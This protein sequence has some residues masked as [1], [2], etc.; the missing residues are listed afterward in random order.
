MKKIRLII[1]TLCICCLSAQA[2]VRIVN[3]A[4]NTAIS[5]SPAFIDA[6]SNRDINNST[7]VGKGLI[8]PRVDLTAMTEFP[9]VAT[10]SSTSFPT[11]FDGMLVYNTAETGVAGVGNTEGTLSPGFW[12]YENKTAS[13]DGGTWKRLGSGSGSGGGVP[14]GSVPAAP[15]S[16]SFSP[17]PV[18]VG[19][20]TIAYC[21][22]VADATMYVWELPA[23]LSATSLITSANTLVI[24]ANATG[25]YSPGSVKVRVAN[26][27]GMNNTTTSNNVAINVLPGAGVAKAWSSACSRQDKSLCT[28]SVGS[29]VAFADASAAQRNSAAGLTPKYWWHS[30]LMETK[31]YVWSRF[32]GSWFQDLLW[33]DTSKFYMVCF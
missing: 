27:C 16:V 19:S 24:N 32:E 18:V 25:T 4:N 6:S 28:C 13:N 22:A 5:D 14:C 29:P 26:S 23:G 12:Y 11:R 15:A 9:G 7:N 30:R 8:F 3:S 33:E 20:T 21:D 10:G 1:G 17:N 31:E 2:Q